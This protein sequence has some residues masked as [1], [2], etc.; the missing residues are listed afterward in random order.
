MQ[1]SKPP[2][3]VAGD[4][5]VIQSILKLPAAPDHACTRFSPCSDVDA[6]LLRAAIFALW[7]SILIR[8]PLPPVPS[9]VA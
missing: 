7:V 5:P 4:D 8:F 6:E 2:G 3:M 1:R 9:P